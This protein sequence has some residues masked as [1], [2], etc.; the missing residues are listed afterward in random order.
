[1]EEIKTFPFSTVWEHYCEV[2]GVPKDLE[3]LD[4]VKAYERKVVA[5][6]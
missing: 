5:E 1:M 6:R 4:T 3:W 2:S